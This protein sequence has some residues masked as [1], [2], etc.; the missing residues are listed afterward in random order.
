[1]LK[2]GFM[3]IPTS[4][5][6]P[7]CKTQIHL[8]TFDNKYYRG[9]T[10][11]ILF[12]CLSPFLFPDSYLGKR[13]ELWKRCQ[14]S[15]LR[16]AAECKKRNITL[17]VAVFPILIRLKGKYIFD[18]EMQTIENFLKANKIICLN[19][20]PD[21]LGKKS[22]SLWTLPHDTHPNER[23]HQIAAESIYKFLNKNNLIPPIKR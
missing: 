6:C 16:I 7:K 5:I 15:L 3:E 4:A 19:M 10:K 8:A 18:K 9:T 14:A 13:Q 17:V 2:G 11:I 1:M 12:F 23:G 20:L 21:F 22:K